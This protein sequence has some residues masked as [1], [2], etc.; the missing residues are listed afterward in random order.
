M[1]YNSAHPQVAYTL[2]SKLA[3]LRAE[4][5][6]MRAKVREAAPH[7][8]DS[9]KIRECYL[10]YCERSHVS[11]DLFDLELDSSGPNLPVSFRK[12]ARILEKMSARFG[13]NI[14][15]TD[16][17]DWTLQRSWRPPRPLVGGG[18]CPPQQGRG[19]RRC[20]AV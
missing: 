1:T 6:S 11:S 12:N 16:N 7:W 3:E 4:L 2:E 15:I 19:P 14:I 18:R 8:R 5:L 20:L 17:T 10:R 9:E 13:N